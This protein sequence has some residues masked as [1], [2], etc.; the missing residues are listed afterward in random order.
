MKWLKLKGSSGFKVVYQTKHI[1]LIYLISKVSNAYAKL[2]TVWGTPGRNE[3]ACQ[4]SL[5]ILEIIYNV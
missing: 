1:S 4:L 3:N 5:G 2:C